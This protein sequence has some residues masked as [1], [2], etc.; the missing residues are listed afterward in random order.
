M[1]GSAG[2]DGAP[3]RFPIRVG[4]RSRWVIRL[5]GATPE[6]A[7]AELDG[8]F[9]ARFGPSQLR[10][11]LTNLESWRIEGPF[12]WIKAIGVRRSFR[13]GDVSFAGSA[14]GGVRI[15]FR[16]PLRWGPL[17]V[18]ALYVG[19]D[20]LEGAAAALAALGV[21]GSDVRRPGR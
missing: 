17:R 16:E 14:H 19:V 1:S 9:H 11:P 18:P 21:P 2:L 10:T 6:T 5:W 15:E 13:G 12:T 3:V 7:W 4:R 20:D 8:G